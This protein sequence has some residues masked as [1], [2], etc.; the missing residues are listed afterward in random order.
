MDS[1]A[2]SLDLLRDTYNYNHWIFSL[3]RPWLG[4]NV[5]EIGSGPGNM[6]RFLFDRECL[7]CVEPSAV[8][9]KNLDKLSQVHLNISVVRGD[10]SVLET[11]KS[12]S[13]DT[14]VCLNVLEHIEDD[15]RAIQRFNRVLKDGGHLVLYVP[16]CSWAYGVIDKN[17]DHYC[18]YNR[19]LLQELMDGEGFDVVKC[20]YVN[21]IG[22]W[23]WVWSSRI[24]GDSYIHPEKARFVDRLVPFISAIERVVR[25][26]VG[27]SLF[28]VGKKREIPI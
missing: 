22:L 14:V 4:G 27:Q 16:A 8:Y 12:N 26:F 24:C 10:D 25:P 3:I 13:Y 18:R 2:Q 28:L 6:T 23:G 7:V 5:L 9:C 17:L 20:H 19:R 15:A 21:F 11:M 1:L